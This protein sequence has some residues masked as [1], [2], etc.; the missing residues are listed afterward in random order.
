[1]KDDNVLKRLR[2]I[3]GHL[4]GGQPVKDLVIVAAPLNADPTGQ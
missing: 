3:E 2:I 4:L 1:M